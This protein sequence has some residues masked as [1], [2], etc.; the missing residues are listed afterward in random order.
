MCKPEVK[1]HTMNW[2]AKEGR[3]AVIAAPLEGIS[4]EFWRD[5]A[6]RYGADVTCSE[7]ISAQALVR[8]IER[9]F[10]KLQ[11]LDRQFPVVT[12][13]FG[14][15]PEAMAEAAEICVARGA[16]AIDINLG[17]PVKKIVKNGWGSMLM[18][19]P[20]KIRN[21]VRA[22]R[23]RI[24]IPLWIKMR[25]GWDKDSMNYLEIGSIAQE[26]GVDAVV[27]HGRTRSQ[28]FT[29]EACWESVGK[30]KAA[31]KIPVIGSGDV[32]SGDDALRRFKE[33]ECD[34]I[35]IGRAALGNPWI[36]CE[37]L[38]ALGVKEESPDLP[39][40]DNRLDVVLEHLRWMT[41]K[42]GEERGVRE[43]RKHL[44]WY[45][46]GLSGVRHFRERVL[47]MSDKEGVIAE[48]TR[49]FGEG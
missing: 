28:A 24:E 19:E 7:M 38:R 30:L 5:L 2:L 25:L 47:D 13:L 32:R 21:I 37:I 18:R 27:L 36:F 42:R 3:P 15:D 31:L 1:T 10:E 43:M 45:S 12:Q 4:D 46:G 22:I 34:G 9:S 29:G 44:V 11:W 26:E 35:M 41:A 8:N 49:F 33:T 40:T 16:A 6:I 23:S 17:C 20:E 48:I 14:N 39:K